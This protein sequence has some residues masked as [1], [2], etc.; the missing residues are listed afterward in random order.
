M[1]TIQFKFQPRQYQL[2][3][4]KAFDNGVK[5]LVKVWHRRSGKDLVDLNIMIAAMAEKVGNYYYFLPNYSQ[6]RKV[7]WDGKTKDGTAFLDYFPPY[8]VA[9]INNSELKIKFKNGSLF[10]LI[11]TDNID[12]IVGTN[13]IGCVFSEFSLQDPL[14]WSYIRPILAENDGWAIFNFT[15]RGMNHA[16]N[17]LQQAKEN[18]SWFHEVLSVDNT[19]AISQETLDDEKSQMPNDLF[20]QEYYCTFLEDAGAVFKKVDD[21]IYDGNITVLNT[22]RYQLGVDLAKYQD[23]TV[24]TPIDLTDFRVG[25][26]D[27]FNIIDYNLQKAR[28]E[29]FYYKHFK[30]RTWIDSTGVGEPIY[31]D[32]VARGLTQV[33]PFHFTEKSRTDLLNNLKLLIEQGTIKLPRYEILLNEL[34]SFHYELVGERTIKM[35]VPEG[36][37]DDT[38][39][40][41]A[42]AV[43]E[44]PSKLVGIVDQERRAL[45]KEFDFYNKQNRT[46]NK[47]QRPNYE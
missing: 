12:S 47:L 2:P 9:S 46:V 37:H 15:P 44:L 36:M 24:L 31:D 25:L 26:P 45:I 41:L 11:G 38:V 29:G 17:V 23:Y 10:Q 21:N 18:A 32:L 5:R 6:A 35:R 1:A 20:M 16:W 30:P 8:L 40:S 4:L 22:H 7:I 42:L 14:A 19:H 3:L 43:W 13:P 33:N 34:K 27:R 39:M 28:I